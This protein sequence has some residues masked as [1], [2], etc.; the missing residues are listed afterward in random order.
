MGIIGVVAAWIIN[1]GNMDYLD[2]SH[3]SYSDAGVCNKTNK[4]RSATI[5]SC[6]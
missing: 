6:K 3:T 5:T 1:T 4:Q 2:A